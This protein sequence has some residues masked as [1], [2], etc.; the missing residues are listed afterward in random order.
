MKWLILHLAHMAVRSGVWPLG[1]TGFNGFCRWC[2]PK[3]GNP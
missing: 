1:G 2:L 3:E